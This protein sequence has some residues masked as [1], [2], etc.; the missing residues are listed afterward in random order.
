M[1]VSSD[2]LRVR[3]MRRVR[4]M[5]SLLAMRRCR[6][7]GGPL[8]H[9]LRSLAVPSGSLSGEGGRA[10]AACRNGAADRPLLFGVACAFLQTGAQHTYRFLSAL[11][12]SG[13]LHGLRKLPGARQLS[14]ER[15][16]P[17]AAPLCVWFWQL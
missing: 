10:R 5:L 8:I 9:S 1:S 14:A 11:S 6:R 7:S 17:L 2:K 4:R 3:P 13:L 12:E 15:R 16:V